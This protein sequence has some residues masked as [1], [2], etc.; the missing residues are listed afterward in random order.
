MKKILFVALLLSTVLTF[1][2]Q[3]PPQQSL[4]NVT[5]TGTV[6]IVPDKVLIKARV[7]HSGKSAAEVKAQND[8]VVN[9]IIKYLKSK[10][11]E[12]KNFQTEYLNLN[13]DYNYNTKETFY[14]ANQAISIQLNDLK[15]YEEIMS[16]L[17]ETG[18]NRIDGIE[19]QT[20][21]R[22]ELESE[23]RKLA[24]LNARE[25]ASEYA[26]ALGQSIGQAHSISEVETG[27]FPPMY[28]AMEMKSADSEEKQTIAPG[29]MEITSKVNV[30]FILL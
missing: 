18:L 21:K 28:R 13:K 22:E 10:G 5:G 23:A 11:I 19:F 30:G 16:G 24:V 2:Q 20:S 27:N 7:E 3:Q 25:K 14:S 12:A 17:L 29:E 1:G 15:R 9:G 26:Q 4:V 6:H 8:K